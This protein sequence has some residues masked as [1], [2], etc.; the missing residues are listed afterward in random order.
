MIMR[1]GLGVAVVA[2][3]LRVAV[4]AVL[5]GGAHA[6][7]SITRDKAVQL[8]R[9]ARKLAQAHPWVEA[10]TKF[11]ASLRTEPTLDRRLE[12]ADCHVHIGRLI[13]AWRLYREASELAERD[14]DSV[15]YRRAK[16]QADDLEPRLARLVLLAPVNLPAGFVVTWGGTPVDP[17]HWVWGSTSIR[18]DTRSSPRHPASMRSSSLSLSTKARSRRWRS[19]A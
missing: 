16:R 10:C 19:R 8:A 12:L 14:D 6:E 11:E 4:V 1:H 5:A 3:V 17:M 18:G 9:D 13:S 15:R 2:V 7:S